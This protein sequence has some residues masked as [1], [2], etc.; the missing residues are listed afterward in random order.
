MPSPASLLHR[1]DSPGAGRPFAFLVSTTACARDIRQNMGNADYSYVFVLNALKPIL[2]PLGTWKLV[3]NPESSLAYQASRA[4][5]EGYRPVHLSLNPPQNAYLTPAVPTVMF[6]FWEFPQIPDRNFGY[7]TRQN[8]ARMCRHADLVLTAC[9]FTAEAFRGAGIDCPVEVVPVPLAPESFRVPDWDPAGSW[10]LSCRHTT[11]GP[12]ADAQDGEH[13]GSVSAPPAP[14]WK[15]GLR[16]G[17]RRIHGVYKNRVR[18]WISDEAANKIFQTKNALLRRAAYQPPVLPSTPL[19]L[20]GLVYTSIFNLGDRRKNVEDML[21]AFLSAFRDRP[22]ATLV[23][24]LATNPK[25]EYYE[26]KELGALYA[27]LNIRHDCRVVVITDYL[28][29]EQLGEL[30]RVTTFYLNASR[31]EGACLPVQEAMAAGRP[32]LAP[33]HTAMADYMDDE[34]GFV[35]ASHP[36]ATFWPHDSEHR[37]DSTWHRLVWSDLRDRLL[38]SA[39]VAEDDPARYRRLSAAARERMA[40]HASRAVATEAL[41]RALE[42]LPESEPGAHSWAA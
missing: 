1:T 13:G 33:R 28:T 29:E 6:P 27:R 36:E 26:L 38:E 2:E 42:Q 7:D 21:T 15:R 19:T 17:Y 20:R 4:W 14:R 40:G 5:A 34:A 11:F 3:P 31:A 10:T 25:R 32:A 12:S 24:K 35:V 22:D 39:R 8:W 18:R 9:R 37:Y 41:R 30:M 16:A 23:L